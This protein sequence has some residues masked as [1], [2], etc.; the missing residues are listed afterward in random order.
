MSAL[1][2][3]IEPYDHGMLDTGDGNRLYFEC[4]GNPDG[5]P[6]VV[7]HGGPGSGCSAASRRYFD[8]SAYRI[9]LFDQRNCGRSLPNAADPDCDLVANT[10]WHLVADIERLREHLGVGRWI[11]F[12]NSWGTTLA[13]AYGQRHPQHVAGMI[14]AGV[15]TTRR[16]EIDWL[17]SGMARFFPADYAH[18]IEAIPHSLRDRG[19]LAAYFAMLNGPDLDLRQAAALAWHRWEAA[20]ILL[21]DPNGMPRRWADPRYLLMRARIVTHYFH[22][23]AWLKD[24]Q[25]LADASKLRGL[26]AMLIQGRFDLEAP[27]TTAWE[28][29]QSWPEAELIIIENAAHSLD[30]SAIAAAIVDAAAK[31]LHFLEK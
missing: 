7:S 10:T 15:T 25:L 11:L 12:G 4:C 24:R 26:P 5:L 21:A 23:G 19:P 8:P 6:V 27:L 30:N 28:L 17:C 1:F 14:L 3:E 22:H 13:L 18:F 29:A 31:F 16:S 9:I 20:S 2:P